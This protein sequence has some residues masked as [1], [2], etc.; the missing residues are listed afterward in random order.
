ARQRRY[1]EV[2]RQIWNDLPID[3]IELRKLRVLR[4]GCDHLHARKV[5]DVVRQRRQRVRP[6]RNG[7]EQREGGKKH[8]D[9]RPGYASRA[10]SWR[11]FEEIGWLG[12]R[13]HG[14]LFTT[15]DH[16]RFS[17]ALSRRRC[18]K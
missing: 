18:A 16:T 14:R 1:D 13:M 11:Q 17:R 4:Q 8:S 6:D 3:L 2:H 9:L 7:N 12:W 5:I 10:K 15:P